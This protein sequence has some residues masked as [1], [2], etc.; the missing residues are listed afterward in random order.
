MAVTEPFEVAAQSTTA[1]PLVAWR[2][3]FFFWGYHLLQNIC[4]VNPWEAHRVEVSHF[5]CLKKVLIERDIFQLLGLWIWI[6]RHSCTEN[7]NVCLSG[8][9][10]PSKMSAMIIFKGRILAGEQR[11]RGWRTCHAREVLG[12]NQFR[13]SVCW[14]SMIDWFSV[15]FPPTS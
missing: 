12:S 5:H 10:C 3:L 6:E 13:R 14:V 1:L 8:S 7:V 15:Q 2:R 11:S 9:L 4:A